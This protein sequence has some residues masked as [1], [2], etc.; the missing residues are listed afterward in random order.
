MKPQKRQ[1]KATGPS[2][3]LESE[4]CLYSSYSEC[5]GGSETSSESCVDLDANPTPAVFTAVDKSFL[6]QILS[7][8]HSQTEM[9]RNVK[10]AIGKLEN[11]V[12]KVQG[13]VFAQSV[14]AASVATESVKKSCKRKY[15]K[16]SMGTIAT[17]ATI[18]F[19]RKSSQGRGLHVL[20][21]VKVSNSNK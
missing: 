17:T 16:K 6:C 5:E 3:C 11:E 21:R 19:T 10:I 14:K 1:S 8:Q 4:S 7:L 9:L 15:K 20:R 13:M 18:D 12:A 2:D